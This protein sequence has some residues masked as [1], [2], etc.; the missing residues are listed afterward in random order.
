VVPDYRSGRSLGLSRAA[1]F[2]DLARRE[3]P[4]QADRAG[5]DVGDP[6]TAHHHTDLYDL[7]RTTAKNILRQYS[8]SPVRL[9]RAVTLEFLLERG[10][11]HGRE[12]GWQREPY[13]QGLLSANDHSRGGRGSAAGR[14]GYRVFGA[15]SHD[16]LLRPS[17]DLAAGA[18][19]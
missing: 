18:F 19:A 17:T 16:A 12:S 6:A 13:Y 4:L 14:S 7:S 10:D 5:R 9:H 11:E 15:D 2:P 8:L 3:G 1:L